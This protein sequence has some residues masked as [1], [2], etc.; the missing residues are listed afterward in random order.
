MDRCDGGSMWKF[1]SES[2]HSLSE[3]GRKV[4]VRMWERCWGLKREGKYA[5]GAG[6]ELSGNGG[7]GVSLTL[8]SCDR[9]SSVLIYAAKDQMSQ[10][11]LPDCL[12]R[13]LPI[14][15]HKF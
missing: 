8:S 6:T 5:K 10:S 4:R 14:F 9:T 3:I 13:F 15:R 7:G 12:V 2:S 1:S 11:L